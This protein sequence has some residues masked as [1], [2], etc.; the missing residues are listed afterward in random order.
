MKFKF[1]PKG[2]YHPGQTIVI[3]GKPWT[4]DSVSHTGRNLEVT[5]PF[6]G[7]TNMPKFERMLVILTDAKPIVEIPA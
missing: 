2:D 1:A 6:N 5:T 4:I 7:Y 3:E